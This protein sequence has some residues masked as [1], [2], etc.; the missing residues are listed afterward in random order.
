MNEAEF[1]RTYPRLYHMAHGGS[2][3]AIRAEGLMSAQ[4]LADHYGLAGEDR[5]RLLSRRR[6]QSV[7]L[8]GDDRPGAMVRDQKP[9]SD[10]ALR[11]CLQDRMSPRDWY[12]H[13]NRFTFFWVSR[14]RFS[15][16]LT[17]RAYRDALQ[18]TL[19]IDTASLVAA[20]RDGVWLSPLN[21]GSTLYQPRPRGRGTFKRMADFP[22]AE[23]ARTRA[24]SANVVELLVEGSVPDMADHVLAVH[25]V[26]GGET[27]REVWRSARA[28]DDDHL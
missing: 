27:L 12:E 13:L 23:R 10:A 4:S 6:P 28:T 9:M 24:A 25:E 20:N 19:T 1:V 17:A 3:P 16:L 22:F 7:P 2:W 11:K 14:E 21:S 15:N 18:T 5:A 8:A 26:L